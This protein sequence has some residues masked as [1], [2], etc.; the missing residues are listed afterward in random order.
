MRAHLFPATPKQPKLVFTFNL[1]DWFKALML[2][3]Q[4]SAEDFVAA[5][6]VMTD[7]LIMKVDWINTSC[8]VCMY[9]CMSVCMYKRLYPSNLF[10]CNVLFCPG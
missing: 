1:L 2:E 3:C 6:G 8:T 5:V 4:V 7:T 10:T 9:I